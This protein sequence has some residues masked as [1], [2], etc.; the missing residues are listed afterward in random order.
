MDITVV[1]RIK[2]GDPPSTPPK[3]NIP[4]GMKREKQIDGK[5]NFH[6]TI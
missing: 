1:I 4:E 2:N 3:P 6:T 5:I